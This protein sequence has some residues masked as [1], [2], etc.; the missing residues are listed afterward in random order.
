[1]SRAAHSSP[2]TIQ[3]ERQTQRLRLLTLYEEPQC[4]GK[5]VTYR[6]HIVRKEPQGDF[7]GGAYE[8]LDRD[9]AALAHVELSDFPTPGDWL[10]WVDFVVQHGPEQ[11]QEWREKVRTEAPQ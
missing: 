5:T 11:A 2:T 7:E 9:G 4:P 1:M 10:H 6:N 3:R 8:V